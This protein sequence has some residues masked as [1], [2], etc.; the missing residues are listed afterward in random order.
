M[1]PLLP[2]T[3]PFGGNR[4][5]EA[6]A[7]TGKTHAIT[8]LYLRALLGHGTPGNQQFHVRNI[9]VLTFTIA[10]T[11]ELR[12]RIR[13]RILKA[14]TDFENGSSDDKFI[15]DLVTSG[16]DVDE[17]KTRLLSASK[18]LDDASIMTIHGFCARVAT[19][20]AFETAALFDKDLVLD[21][22]ALMTGAATDFY[23]QQIDE[24][25]PEAAEVI[26]SKYPSPDSLLADISTLIHREV[27]LRPPDH[28]DPGDIGE[29]K[30]LIGYIK[31]SW[32]TENIPLLLA[33]SG[34]NRSRKG[35]KADYQTLMKD[36]AMSDRMSFADN[37][38]EWTL[39][40]RSTL[41]KASTKKGGPPDHPIFDAFEQVNQALGRWSETVLGNFKRQALGA[42]R[43]RLSREKTLTN[44]LTFDDLLI[45]LRDALVRDELEDG[46]RLAAELGRRYPLAIVDEFQ[47]TDDIQYEIFAKIYARRPGTSLIVI[48]DPKQAIYKFR[49]ADIFTYIDAKRAL[50]NPSE[51]LFSLA[52]NWRATPQMV[53]A[54]NRLFDRPG[55]FRHADIPYTRVE[56]AAEKAGIALE[57]NGIPLPAMTLFSLAKKTTKRDARVACTAWVAE[58]VSQLLGKGL[59]G[60]A[61]IDGKPLASG[62]IAILTRDRYDAE[63]VRNA[64]TARNV[65]SVYVTLE[66]VLRMPIATELL[67]ILVAVLSPANE[68]YLRSALATRLMTA[69]AAEI[70]AVSVDVRAHQDLTT[71]FV[72]YH[73][74]W[75]RSGVASMINAMIA[76]RGLAARGLQQPDGE[77]RM[78]DLRHLAELLQQRAA[79]APGMHR[80]VKWYAREIETA[81][82]VAP[83]ARQLRLESDHNLVQIVTMHS[84]KGLEYDVVFVPMATFGMLEKRAAI[85]HEEETDPGA[86]RSHRTVVDLEGT[87]DSFE[88][89]QQE[90]LA[91]DIRLLYVAATRAKYKCYMGIADLRSTPSL[92][93]CAIG[94][95]IGFTGGDLGT[96]LSQEFGDAG[97]ELLT[98]D[99]EIPV[100]R[101]VAADGP[102][103]TVAPPHPRHVTG[104]WRIHSYTG[105]TRSLVQAPAGANASMPGLL[106]DDQPDE[107]WIPPAAKDRFAFPRGPRR[108]ILL[109]L[110]LEELLGSDPPTLEA[111]CEHML[112]RFGLGAEWLQPLVGWIDNVLRTPLLAAGGFALSDPGPRSNEMEFVFPMAGVHLP[113]IVS[114]AMEN[115]YLDNTTLA[116][117]R[118]S[119]AMTGTIDLVFE[120]DGRFFLADYKSNHLGNT[121]GDYEGASLQHA[122]NA[123]HYDLQYL[124]YTV[125]LN[126]HLVRT[127]P[128][129]R[130][131]THFGGVLYLFLRGMYADTPD[132][133]V[134]HDKPDPA[135]IAALDA[136]LSYPATG[137]AANGP[138]G[139]I[140]S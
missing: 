44:T 2:L 40:A 122:V 75:S 26:L 77:R 97:F 10:A 15:S 30:E 73:T 25:G 5:I 80:L 52:T 128:G 83:E 88:L 106:D 99:G 39:W 55:M 134:F 105:L 54:I 21:A 22:S 31:R 64:L 49:G 84:A 9:L 137:A 87:E 123:H 119:G 116:G 85:Y 1:K 124:I 76:Q 92:Q 120:R 42:V 43:A 20:L 4:M 138:V 69:T 130:Y 50:P 101:F 74:L 56:A 23:R 78:T 86:T 81:T 114:L 140:A 6:S 79:E 108:G 8:N 36:F 37:D 62:Q 19:D 18:L 93:D 17:A 58:Q 115:G 38:L 117:D 33:Q 3:F 111:A 109:H 136:Q 94:A 133:G 68:R 28:A 29:I 82:T 65:K 95:A 104:N 16:L 14:H 51:D 118:L 27:D 100:T 103:Q 102:A 71:E 89:T 110:L 57:D 90:Q 91:E 32:I 121:R 67:A 127:V 112:T 125:A 45:N 96:H 53:D 47:D 66:S 132:S 113:A 98:I 59:R 7:G 12:G 107:T 24:L 126:R 11:E 72:G 48:G 63:A 46:G 13:K 61:T 60:E 70:D 139:A 135:L 35:M 131:E 41:E 129:Y 34:L